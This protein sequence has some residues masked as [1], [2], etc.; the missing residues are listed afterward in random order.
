MLFYRYIFHCIYHMIARYFFKFFDKFFL[1]RA[2]RCIAAPRLGKN[3]SYGGNRWAM[4]RKPLSFRDQFANWSWE[5]VSFPDSSMFQYSIKENGLP[6]RFAPRNDSG[7]FY[8]ALSF[9]VCSRLNS[10]DPFPQCAR[11]GLPLEWAA[12]RD[13][14][15]R[16]AQRHPRTPSAPLLG[17]EAAAR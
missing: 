5:S 17:S 12:L 16:W 13:K 6:R 1:G 9:A 8:V 7:G 4:S 3:V 15:F 14:G 10:G 2:A 11:W